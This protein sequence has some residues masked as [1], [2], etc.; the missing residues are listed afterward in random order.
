MQPERSLS[1]ALIIKQAQ[2]N[3]GKKTKFVYQE[4]AIV[5]ALKDDLT[6]LYIEVPN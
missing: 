2:N 1:N 6:L 5:K 4:S 3:E